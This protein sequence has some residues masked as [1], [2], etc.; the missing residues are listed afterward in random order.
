MKSW[1]TSRLYGQSKLA[2]I[3]HARELARRY[4]DIISVSLHPGRVDSNLGNVM[5]Q[6]VLPFEF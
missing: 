1:G 3:L 6:R 4:L 5:L 2:N